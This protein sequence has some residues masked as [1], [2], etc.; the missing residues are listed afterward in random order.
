MSGPELAADYA[1]C[2]GRA[3]TGEEIASRASAGED[4]ATAA[5]ERHASRLARGLAHV[6][7]IVDP[8]VIVL[9][10]G[11]SGL[12]HLY[13]ELPALMAPYVFAEAADIVVRPPRWGDASG[14]RGAAW[15][16]PADGAGH[17]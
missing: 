12:A 13:R 10:G 7:N 5:L 11:L 15:L 8:E 17:P 6:V 9:G 3:L 16:W 14:V 2:T 4:A 1:R